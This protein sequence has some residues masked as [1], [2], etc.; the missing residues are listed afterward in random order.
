MGDDG[1]RSR[2]WFNTSTELAIYI[3]LHVISSDNLKFTIPSV[4]YLGNPF[5]RHEGATFDIPHTSLSQTLQ[6]LEL[7]F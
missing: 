7:G 2:I 6:Q 1:G 4:A 5:R 3:N